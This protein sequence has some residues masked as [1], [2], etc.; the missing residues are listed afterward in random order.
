VLEEIDRV[1][2]SKYRYGINQKGYRQLLLELNSENETERTR[3]HSALSERIDHAFNGEIE[4]IVDILP[5]LLAY[6]SSPELIDVADTVDLLSQI[7]HSL[8]PNPKEPYKTNI[9]RIRNTLC[10]FFSHVDV[11]ARYYVMAD[12]L[13]RQ[14]ID[15]IHFTCTKPMT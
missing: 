15:R 12:S 9:G 1:D 4:L 10:P 8:N 2:W 3:A 14:E 13:T 6:L 5:V 7:I 11:N